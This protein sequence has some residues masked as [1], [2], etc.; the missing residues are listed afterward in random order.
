MKNTSDQQLVKMYLKGNGLAFEEL[1]DRYYKRVEYFFYKMLWND[2]EK[3]E[4]YAQD[5]FLKVIEKLETF[6]QELSFKTWLFSIANNMCKNEYRKKEVEQRSKNHF[7]QNG[8]LFENS[9]AE[10]KID[11]STF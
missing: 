2:K 3:A 11:E 1:F 5:L 10:Q 4:D 8:T 7:I 9:I 6:N